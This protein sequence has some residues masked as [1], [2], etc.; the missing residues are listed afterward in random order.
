M[1][2][3]MQRHARG[4]RPQFYEVPGLDEAMS[5]IMVLA[6]EL[7]VVRDRLDT[8]EKVAAAKGIILDQDIEAFEPDEAVLEAR[9]VR[10]QDF[11]SRLFYLARKQA[12]EL[13]SG[14]DD[15]RYVGVLDD[16][17]KS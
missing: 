4:K 9:E 14:D 15:K 12:H 10:R 1:T 8:V 2:R 3:Q 6:N 11:L 5:M 13:Q 7:S 17:A 16:I